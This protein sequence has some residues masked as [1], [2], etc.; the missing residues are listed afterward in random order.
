MRERID[1]LVE[2]EG[3]VEIE[4]GIETV[5]ILGAKLD[6]TMTGHPDETET[7]LTT[8]EVVVVEGDEGVEE[9]TEIE[10][11]VTTTT[12]LQHS[13]RKVQLPHPRRKSLHRILQM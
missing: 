4:N 13:A 10:E 9:A 7:Y 6:E 1:T 2:I 3:V 5:E 12:N 8:E 11:I